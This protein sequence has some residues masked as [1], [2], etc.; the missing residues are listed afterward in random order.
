MGMRSLA[1]FVLP[2]LMP[3][4]LLAAAP[5]DAAV[6]YRFAPYVDMAEWPPPDLGEIRTA[7]GV[8]HISLGFVTAEEKVK[9]G[10]G[11]PPRPPDAPDQECIPTWGGYHGYPASGSGAYKLAEVAAHRA[12]GGDIVG[13]FGGQAGFE[14][15]SVCTTVTDLTDA[16]REVIE[17]YDLTHVDFDIE[18]AIVPNTTFNTNR[19]EAIAALQEE[20]TADGRALVVSYT[21]AV[22][23]SGLLTEGVALLQNAVDHGVRIDLV[24]LMTMDFS[25]S[26]VPEPG[27]KMAQYSELAVRNAREQIR[28]VFP[29]LTDADL[30][31]K[32]GMTAMI[33]VND[34]CCA[35]QV[36]TPRAASTLANW[37]GEN[38]IGMLGMWSLARDKSCT[39]ELNPRH[40]SGV[41][42]TPWTFSHRLGAFAGGTPPPPDDGSSA[43]A[44]TTVRG[45]FNADGKGDLAIAAPGE[46][47]GAGAVHVLYGSASGLTADGSQLWSQSSAGIADAPEIGDGFGSA[48][49]A[50]DV[51]RDGKTD[52]AIGAPRENDGE[53]VVHVL[54]GSAGAGLT[55][56][57]SQLWSQAT[58]G[59]AGSPLTDDGFG[60]ALA[61]GDFGGSTH[62][63][64][65][66][67]VPDENGG[68]M[69]DS[70]AVHVLPGSATGPGAA[71]SQYWTQN[72][73]G[74]A[75]NAES[76]DRFGAS[77]AAGDL[78]HSTRADLVIGATGERNGAGV[79]HA[80]YGTDAGLTATNQQQWSQSTAGIA[81]SGAAGDHFGAALAIGDFGG[82]PHGDLAVG[83]PEDGGPPDSG[84][85]HVLPG[86]GTGLT[87]TGSQLWTQAS[88]GVF[89]FVE[90]GDR[91]GATLAAGDLGRGGQADLA[92]GVPGENEGAGFVH[93]IYGTASGLGAAD[94]Q[95]WSQDTPGIVNSSF[96]SDHFGATLAI[97]N[98]GGTSHSE[99]AVGAPDENSGMVLDTGVLHVLPGSSTGT[100]ATGAQYWHQNASGVADGAEL[101]DR[102]GGAAGR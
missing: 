16:Y 35:A 30:F 4:A 79:V 100:T 25:P 23:P 61:I 81:G 40:C 8:Q 102:F 63:D 49:A 9:D 36:Y 66:V 71:G 99:L 67:G 34:P 50:G 47:D 27:T 6:P 14:L 80:I 54:L 94:Q 44:P 38:G 1:R 17:T 101:G 12:A 59:V 26:Q 32:L 74:I 91:F 33:G 3:A 62:G 56:T 28:A 95:V 29:G 82:T 55:A 57:G 64:L 75:D 60:A 96:P 73:S 43:S 58:P 19:A 97:G 11:D 90:P 46:N 77:L 48:V 42:Q 52:L 20:A 31:A 76:A 69:I 84:G 92:I 53:G 87:A 41:T 10:P 18:G 7:G 24:N 45:D 15:A 72:S 88:P 89:D 68:T 83:A 13:S 78:G 5:A 22:E 93:T 21:V 39:P 85:V 65:A 2:L 98:F 51:N 70:G 86:S 37:A